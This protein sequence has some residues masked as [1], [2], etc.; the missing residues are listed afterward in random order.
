[1]ENVELRKKL[2][3][4][5]DRLITKLNSLE[6]GSAEYIK[7]EEN[8]LDINRVLHEDEKME[9]EAGI[10]KQKQTA[11]NDRVRI[12]QDKLQLEQERLNFESNKS[13]LGAV[14]DFLGGMSTIGL[15]RRQWKE[16]LRFEQTGTIR[17]PQVKGIQNTIQSFL[18]MKIFNF[19]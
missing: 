10:A 8:L 13:L 4:E 11:D 1:M 19:K 7:V 17:T 15:I 12:E 14:L 2:E 5:A 3:L 18:H 6:P 16:G 9:I